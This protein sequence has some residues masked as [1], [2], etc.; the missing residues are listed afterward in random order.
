M[1]RYTA[2]LATAHPTTVLANAVLNNAALANAALATVLA[3]IVVTAA[4]TIALSTGL[5]QF[6]PKALGAPPPV[7]SLPAIAFS[8]KA[9][10]SALTTRYCIHYGITQCTHYSLLHSLRHHSVQQCRQSSI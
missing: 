10:T 5:L 4:P 7:H 9:P 1:R 8:P 2:V 6:T 3:T